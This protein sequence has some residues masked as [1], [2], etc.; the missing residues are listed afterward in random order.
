MYGNAGLFK[1]FPGQC[2]DFVVLDGQDLRQHLDDRH[3]GA[4]RAVEG[5]ELDAD[6][7]RAD[8][9]QRFRHG[10]GHHRLKVGP[11]QLA[12]GLNTGQRA[13]PGAGGDNDVLCLV[14]A[15]A[16][17]CPRR[18]MGRLHG[19]PGR[20][21]D[22]HLARLGD[23]R[24]TP[25]DVD[26]V[27]LQQEADALV[28]LAGD[29]A[30]A[31]DDGANIEADLLRRQ[32]VIG[33]MLHVMV[34]L[35]GAQQRL[36][37]DAAPVEADAAEMLALDDGGL[38]A[39]LGGAD[40]GDVAARPAADD[41][42][43]I[44]I[45]HGPCTPAP[46]PRLAIRPVRAGVTGNLTDWRRRSRRIREAHGSHAD[47]ARAAEPTVN[48]ERRGAARQTLALFRRNPRPCGKQAASRRAKRNK[49]RHLAFPAIAENGAFASAPDPE[50]SGP[51]WLP[52]DY[53]KAA[54]PSSVN[55]GPVA[56]A[57]QLTVAVSLVGIAR[58]AV[59]AA[60]AETVVGFGSRAAAATGL[61]AAAG[62]TTAAAGLTTAA[63]FAM[64]TGSRDRHAGRDGHRTNQRN[65]C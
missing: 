35:G 3:L 32:A 46:D 31:L 16:Q 59:T 36:G 30:R 34:D 44:D 33:G 7:A 58:N 64:G 43:V 6:G 39:E 38:E 61:A 28:E 23:R 26:L 22:G 49:T 56:S 27:L 20:S 52:R 55:D 40:G 1:A 41:D 57:C 63:A 29:A 8:D 9:Q 2:G 62:L 12:V 24:L 11:H 42:H 10:V 19:F 50:P 54:G 13:R 15:L 5:R 25:D 47:C 21:G 18:R 45:R 17:R 37:R 48:F 14:G 60:V 4:Q 51:G 65:C 53:R